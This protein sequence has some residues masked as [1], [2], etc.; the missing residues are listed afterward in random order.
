MALGQIMK[1]SKKTRRW[2]KVEIAPSR[3]LRPKKSEQNDDMYN[4]IT[5]IDGRPG[6]NHRQH[7]IR[8]GKRSDTII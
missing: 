3:L 8:R 6:F 5:E 2:M 1:R 4:T 7:F